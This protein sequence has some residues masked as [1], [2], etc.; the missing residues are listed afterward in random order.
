MNILPLFGFVFVY[1]EKNK[2]KLVKIIKQNIL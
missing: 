2:H 1:K